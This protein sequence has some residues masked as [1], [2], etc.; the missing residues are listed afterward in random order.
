VIVFRPLDAERTASFVDGFW[1]PGTTDEAIDEITEF[2]L[3][4]GQEDVDLVESVHRG[5]RAGAIEHG[6]LLLDSEHLIQHF[7]L[8]VHDALT[9]AP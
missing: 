3:V 8:L 7:Q 2:G 1:A 6:R 5:L 4:V 9:G